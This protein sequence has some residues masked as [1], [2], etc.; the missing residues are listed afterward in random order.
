M[1]VI[2][3]PDDEEIPI[4]DSNLSSDL[5]DGDDGPNDHQPGAGGVIN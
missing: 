3:F 1:V 2:L 5:E 4:I